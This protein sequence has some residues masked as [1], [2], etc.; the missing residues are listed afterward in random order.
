MATM[1]RGMT[2]KSCGKEHTFSIREGAMVPDQQYEYTCPI[3]GQKAAVV[4]WVTA[5]VT[6]RLPVGAV[7]LTLRELS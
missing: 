6:T 1:F 7:D 4:P 5:T 2:C 3:S